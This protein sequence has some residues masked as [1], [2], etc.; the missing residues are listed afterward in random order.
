MDYDVPLQE[1]SWGTSKST[2]TLFFVIETLLGIKCE[3]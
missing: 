1:L 3:H 2:L